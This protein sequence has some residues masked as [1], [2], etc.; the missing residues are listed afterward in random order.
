MANHFKKHSL[1]NKLSSE[2]KNIEKVNLYIK[3]IKV[4]FIKNLQIQKGI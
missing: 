4:Y 2:T 1:I 3:I